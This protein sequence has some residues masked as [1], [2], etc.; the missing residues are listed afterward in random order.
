MF[1]KR[2]ATIFLA[3]FAFVQAEDSLPE[4][5]FVPLNSL[6]ESLEEETPYGL[7]R[8][9]MPLWDSFLLMCRN[10]ASSLRMSTLRLRSMFSEE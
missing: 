9:L 6:T 8:E 1:L 4:I 2:V 3:A 7:P 5:Q 10:W